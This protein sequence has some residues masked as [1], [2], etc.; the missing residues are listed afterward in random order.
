[1]LPC[2]R[3]Y[4]IRHVP[5]TLGLEHA[6]LFYHTH[7]STPSP[8]FPWL[9]AIALKVVLCWHWF[10]Y[11]IPFTICASTSLKAPA[12]S[13]LPLQ[14]S[15]R[16]QNQKHHPPQHHIFQRSLFQRTLIQR[17]LFQRSLIQRSLIQRSLFQ[18]TLIQRSLFQRSLIQRS[19]F[20]RTL[21]QRTLIQR[22]LF[23]RSLI[24]RPLFYDVLFS[25]VRPCRGRIKQ[26]PSFWKQ[27]DRQPGCRHWCVYNSRYRSFILTI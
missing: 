18:R 24:R 13:I 4:L 6:S 20:Q 1:M 21:I 5:V 25:D 3:F 15:L 9:S 14:P 10:L 16:T 8:I 2:R 26:F 23:Q 17:S 22:P 27:C 7:S 19:L 12:L 11:P